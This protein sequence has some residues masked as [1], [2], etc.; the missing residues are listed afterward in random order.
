MNRFRLLATA[1]TV[2][3]TTT[4]RGAPGLGERVEAVPRLVRATLDGTYAGTTVKRLALVVA[5]V[6]YVA[7]PLDLLPEAVLPILGAADDAVVA[8]WAIKA[9]LEETDRF[10]AW[11]LGQGR[12]PRQPVVQGTVVDAPSTRQ[13]TEANGTGV[14]E[15]PGSGLRD[16]ATA[17]ALES[18]RRRLER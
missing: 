11:E 8:S 7:S 2:L 3:R 1:A 12:T 14:V 4:R 16:A 15:R 5:A 6:A 17:Y 18:L 9:F 13:R 10:L